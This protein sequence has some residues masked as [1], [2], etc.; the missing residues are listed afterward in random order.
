MATRHNLCTNPALSTVVTGWGGG[1]TPTLTAV[2]GFSRPNAARYSSGTFMSTAQGAAT[3]GLSY[4]VS[5]YARSNNFSPSGTIYIEWLNSGGS[6]ISFSTGSAYSLPSTVVTRASTTAT[7]PANTAFCRVVMDG[8]NYS[9]NVCDI[10]MV[11]LEQAAL[12]TY[13]DGDTG[14]A[15]WDGTTGNSSSTLTTGAAPA[16][17]PR[18]TSQYGSYF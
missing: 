7:A 5:T 8:T 12:D 15:T 13:F 1:S 2:S 14:G 9:V 11:L 10:T 4:T 17:P 16:Y 18:M 3:A 6:S